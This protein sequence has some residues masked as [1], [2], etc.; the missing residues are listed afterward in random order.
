MKNLNQLRSL[1]LDY[2]KR[3]GHTIVHSS[4]LIPHNDP[5]LMFTNSGMVQFKDLF[6]GKEKRNYTRASTSQKS[7]RAGGKHN[8]LDNVGH[9]ARH[10]T[11]FEMLGNFSFGDYFKDDAIRF[12]WELITK[13]IG[14]N[15]ERLYVTVFHEDDEAF[16]LWKKIAGLSEDRIIK[17]NT[18]DNFWSMGDTGPCG[19]CSE[20][21]YDHGDHIFGGLPGTKDQDGDRYVEIWNLVFMQ[22][23]QLT[24]EKRI[25]LP[26]QCIDTGMGLERISAVVQGVHNNY[27]IDLFKDL[28]NA[29]IDIVKTKPEGNA[30]AS[31]R[32]IAD[33]LRSSSFLIAD[34]II[35]SNEGRG[36]VLRRILRRAIR[37]SYQLSYK[38][39]LMHQLL[40]E[41]IT[42][43][44]EAY[45]ELLRAEEFV[46]QILL[47]EEEGF[48]STLEKGMKLLDAEVEQHKG[49]KFSG[50]VAFKLHDTYGFPL[51]LT[52]DILKDKKLELDVT[53][54]DKC[55]DLQKEMARK[56]WSG[57]G[58]RAA[59]DIWFK[60]K[61]DHGTTEFLGYELEEA[62]AIALSLVSDNKTVDKISNKGASFYLVT[63]QTPFYGESGG[64][65]GD[66]GVITSDGL[67]IKVDDTKK[68]IAGLHVHQCTLISGEITSG[69]A[70][71]LIVDSS[72]RKKL[73]AN[74]TSTHLLHAVLRDKLG[75]HVTQSG[76]M[77]AADRLRF[78]INYPSQITKEVLD[79]IEVSINQ[80]ITDNYPVK[81]KLM[82]YDDAVAEGA[83][84]LFGEKYD[85]EVRVVCV[86]N[87]N[88]NNLS[89][90][91]CGGT[92]VSNLGEIGMFKIIS[93]SSIAAGIRRIEAVTG[94]ATLKLMQD[95]E[96]K[97]ANLT[98][99]LKDIDLEE[100]VKCLIENNRKLEKEIDASKG[101]S[102]KSL[103]KFTDQDTTTFSKGQLLSKTLP[104]YEM[105]DI[106]QAAQNLISSNPNSTILLFGVFDDKVS[107]VCASNCNI[108]ALDI[109]NI[110]S[111]TF[112]AKGGGRAD[113]AQGGGEGKDNISKALATI[114][115]FVSKQ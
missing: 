75:K 65:M 1:F 112:S 111:D 12:A 13:E 28:I 82:S 33:H 29:S 52:Q 23:E 90:E 17:I 96:Q 14:L 36:Y 87:D 19:P 51:D 49:H 11:F 58:E 89:I 21:F 79:Q 4:P 40:P 43:M 9:T 61:A 59:Q 104:G 16:N 110:V 54:F 22:Y 31:Y 94:L 53:A 102:L 99:L 6:T 81:T 3:N 109:I 103:L 84:A 57:S 67:V 66:I 105:K 48:I 37:Q 10:H 74:H 80:M 38:K 69:Q 64:Q 46:A 73:R 108:S 34:G 76:S 101:D 42:Q 30:L 78:D 5:T 93:E 107:Y 115:E 15:K 71:K 85:S 86:G 41:L 8:D 91:L 32:I 77:V 44:A 63:N 47:R 39:P 92:H 72:Y 60:I 88:Q 55:M 106:R 114:K 62:E 25:N 97:L 95:Q 27:E 18:S 83:M 24:K 35:P 45:P 70:L 98:H 2:F 56:S 68:P 20:I 113:L 50:E 7:V 100:R 26:M